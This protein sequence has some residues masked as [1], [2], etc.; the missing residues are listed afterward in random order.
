MSAYHAHYM[1]WFGVYLGLEMAKNEETK[2]LFATLECEEVVSLLSGWADEFVSKNLVD[3]WDFF[4]LKLETYKKEHTGRKHVYVITGNARNEDGS[5]E[6]WLVEIYADLQEAEMYR[7][8]L[9]R[10]ADVNASQ[11]DCDPILYLIEEREVK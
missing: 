3:S 2:Q 5:D 11:F 10:D 4:N 8:G 1:T 6:E 9:Q 7:V